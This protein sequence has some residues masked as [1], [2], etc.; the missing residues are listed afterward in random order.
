MDRDPRPE[1]ALGAQGAPP[2]KLLLPPS[3]FVAGIYGRIDVDRGRLQGAG[4]RGR[5]TGL[6]QF[7]S[8][9]NKGRD[10]VLNPEGINALRFF[11]TAATACGARG[12]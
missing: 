4:Q 6:T 5:A 2:Q 10:E 3:G 12:R 9:I 8:N 7:E 1:P 11:P